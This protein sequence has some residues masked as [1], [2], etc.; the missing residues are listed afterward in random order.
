M[1]H[2]FKLHF[3]CKQTDAEFDWQQMSVEG[4]LV[5]YSSSPPWAIGV[6]VVISA[7][8]SSFQEP[9]SA[10]T[11]TVEAAGG[12]HPSCARLSHRRRRR[13]GWQRCICGGSDTGQLMCWLAQFSTTDRGIPQ[14]WGHIWG[15]NRQ[16]KVNKAVYE[17]VDKML[18]LCYEFNVYSILYLLYTLSLVG[19]CEKEIE[20]NEI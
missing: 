6:V 18:H 19:D 3:I 9:F 20:F 1:N 5:L 10:V 4:V 16:V 11:A 15:D 7:A 2:K 8:T 12:H 17:T 14:G 13:A